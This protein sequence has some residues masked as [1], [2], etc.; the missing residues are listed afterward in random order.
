MD[1]LVEA[2]VLYCSMIP[3]HHPSTR[4]RPTHCLAG[5]HSMAQHGGNTLSSHKVPA[6][7]GGTSSSES[8]RS[9]LLA[10][11]KYRVVALDTACNA[12]DNRN[13]L[14]SHQYGTSAV[15]AVFYCAVQYLSYLS[16]C[17][18]MRSITTRRCGGS[19][20]SCA[21]HPHGCESYPTY[22]RQFKSTPLAQS[23][24]DTQAT[25]MSLLPLDIYSTNVLLD[26]GESPSTVQYMGPPEVFYCTELLPS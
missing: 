8:D 26:A 4:S 6:G 20:P 23:P 13:R 22:V 1:S 9:S 17:P 14:Q 15:T 3:R 18:L 12:G 24:R 5:A 16:L 25:P 19:Q 21:C 11:I 2:T 10:V 7:R